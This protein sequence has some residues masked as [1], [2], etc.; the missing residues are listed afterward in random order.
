[1]TIE[2]STKEDL[3]K[4]ILILRETVWERKITWLDVEN[5]LKNFDGKTGHSVEIEQ[6]HALYLLSEFMYFGSNEIRVLLKALFRDL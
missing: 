5:W 6:L 4:R 1:M 3:K 2:E